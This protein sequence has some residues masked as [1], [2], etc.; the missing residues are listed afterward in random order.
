MKEIGWSV[1][2]FGEELV[3]SELDGVAFHAAVLGGFGGGQGEAGFGETE[4]ARAGNRHR[5][6]HHRRLLLLVFPC[7]GDRGRRQCFLERHRG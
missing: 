5:Q 2:G 4:V 3:V 7:L 6:R 1:Q